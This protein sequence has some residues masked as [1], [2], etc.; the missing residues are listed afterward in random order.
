MRRR[1][2]VVQDKKVGAKGTRA[3]YDVLTEHGQVVIT[4]CHIPHGKRVKEYVAQLRMDYV[5]AVERGPVIVVG[6]FNYDPRSSGAETKVNQ[7][8]RL[9]VEEMGLQ[10]VSYNLGG[11]SC[12]VKNEGKGRKMTGFGRHRKIVVLLDIIKASQTS[13]VD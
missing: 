9:F 4:N 6:E 2:S 5:R 1:F 8:V 11:T 3:V 12:M 10:D 13:M 7:E